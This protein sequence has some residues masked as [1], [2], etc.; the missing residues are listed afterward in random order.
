MDTKKVFYLAF[1]S[2]I[3]ATAL[4]ASAS[5]N[6]TA[7]TQD[8][9]NPCYT[10][11]VHVSNVT[12]VSCVLASSGTP[13]YGYF[14]DGHLPASVIRSGSSSNFHLTQRFG[15]SYGPDITLSYLC[16]NQLVTFR[17]QQSACV[18]GW[19]G[20]TNATI[21]YED[22]GI[23]LMY[24]TEDPSFLFATPGRIRWIIKNTW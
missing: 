17:S 1:A 15:M 14:E 3:Y 23:N 8:R 18:S 5:N 7:R 16:G 21:V 10:M 2:F 11:D 6:P 4:T 19:A 24:L 20:R 12:G 22:S 13:V 9:A